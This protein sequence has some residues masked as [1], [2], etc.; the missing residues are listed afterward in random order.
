MHLR[1]RILFVL[2]DKYRSITRG[3]K[4][5]MLDRSAPCQKDYEDYWTP[6]CSLLEGSRPLS[7][8]VSYWLYGH[9][10]G[11]ET[12]LQRAMQCSRPS[13]AE[14]GGNIADTEQ[15][16][17]LAQHDRPHMRAMQRAAI[18][19][20]VRLH[21]VF[22]TRKSKRHSYSQYRLPTLPAYL[23]MH[24][25][26]AIIAAFAMATLTISA[27]VDL[28]EGQVEANH[29]SSYAANLVDRTVEGKVEANRHTPYATLVERTVEGHVEAKHHSPYA[30][31]VVDRSVEGQVEAKHHSPYAAN[32]VERSVES[33][34]EAKHHSPYAANLVERANQGKAE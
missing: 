5:L 15:A 22:P 34:V 20:R 4:A 31:N 6:P 30:A 9:R 14:D 3:S 7:M 2:V 29:H 19:F 25:K 23:I 18:D 8:H 28:V 11:T 10:E 24:F 17:S 12:V 21:S 13:P 16:R 32:I 26:Q 1:K 27:P 33:Q